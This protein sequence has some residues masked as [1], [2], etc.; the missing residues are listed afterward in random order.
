MLKQEQVKDI[1][2]AAFE[3]VNNSMVGPIFRYPDPNDFTYK[4]LNQVAY[5]V[6]AIVLTGMMREVKNV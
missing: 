2:N 3:G 6:Y 1:V 5:G 4:Q